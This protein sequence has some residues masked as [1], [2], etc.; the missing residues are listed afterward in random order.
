MN[1]H[2]VLGI[3]DTSFNRKLIFQSRIGI[4]AFRH[5]SSEYLSDVSDKKSGRNDSFCLWFLL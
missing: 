3:N 1:I 2:T 4:S 5:A